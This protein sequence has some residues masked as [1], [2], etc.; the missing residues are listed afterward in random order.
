MDSQLERLSLLNVTVG[1]TACGNVEREYRQRVLQYLEQ[2]MW[3]DIQAYFEIRDWDKYRHA[4]ATL[5]ETSRGIGAEKLSDAVAQLAIAAREENEYYIERHQAEIMAQYRDILDQIAEVLVEKNPS[6][7]VSTRELTAHLLLVD[8]DQESLE[9]AK[10]I[11]GKEYEL[12]IVQ[13]GKEAFATMEQTV[14]DLL[15]IDV[16]MPEIDGFEMIRML[17]EDDLF[18][19]IPVVFLTT[20]HD[21]EVEVRGFRAGAQDFIVKPFAKEI[22]LQRVGRILELSR[23][24]KNLQKEVE[25]QTK[26]AEERRMQVE[27]LS[28]QIIKALA[29]TIDAKDSY[30]NG[31]SLRV[32]QYA[33]KIAKRAGKNEKE[34]ERIYYM[35]MLHDIG[36]IG[37]PDSIITKNS[38][39]SDK[40]YFVTRKHP[41]I[42]AEIL[43]NISEIP[44]LGIGARWHH[45][46]YDGTGYPDGL[47]GT[48]IPEEA[49]MIAVADAYDA[50]ASKRSYRDVLP[51]QVV[52][53]EIKKGK[54]TQFDPEF[55]DLM[56]LLMEEDKTYTMR[57][58]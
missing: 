25:R 37:I 39:L 49:R 6:V 13:S 26:Q 36:K 4:V 9:T 7:K 41:E 34:Q 43:A 40:E 58:M 29:E 51:Q 8:D 57:E 15:L 28:N 47:K 50:M 30:T 12:T 32:A 20:D 1:L 19:E 11:L 46:R 35:G 16:Y 27:R 48:E 23:L 5:A 38:S 18:K 45:E 10:K 3:G 33:L 53:E 42:G 21:R 54:G 2:E 56:L 17:K 22:M 31:H 24:Q 44:D 52:Y 14:P 55:A